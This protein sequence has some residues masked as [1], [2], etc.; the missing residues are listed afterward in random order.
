M[1]LLKADPCLTPQSLVLKDFP[2][3]NEFPH[4]D[5]G[6][7]GEEGKIKPV[8]I[9]LLALRGKEISYIYIYINLRYHLFLKNSISI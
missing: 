5:W 2:S 3:S 8:S 6:L 1:G 4:W 7:V 9:Y